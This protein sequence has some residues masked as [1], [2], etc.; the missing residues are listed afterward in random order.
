MRITWVACSKLKAT[1]DICGLP[2]RL[3]VTSTPRLRCVNRST[4][5]VSLIWVLPG[6]PASCG[7]GGDMSDNGGDPTADDPACRRFPHQPSPV[8]VLTHRIRALD[9]VST[10]GTVAVV[11]DKVQQTLLLP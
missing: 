11:T 7:S 5:M 3:S 8:D 10:N 4:R 9:D 6:M 2:S 1:L